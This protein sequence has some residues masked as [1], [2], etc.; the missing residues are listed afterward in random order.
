[1]DNDGHAAAAVLIWRLRGDR[2]EVVP[3]GADLTGDLTLFGS[4][5]G[6]KASPTNPPTMADKLTF[7]TTIDVSVTPKIIFIAQKIVPPSHPRRLVAVPTLD[8]ITARNSFG[9]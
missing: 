4:L 2:G 6:P 5:A 8:G 1:M 9:P 7:T 3:H